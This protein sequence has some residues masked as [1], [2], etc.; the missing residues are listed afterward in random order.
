MNNIKKCLI[1]HPLS[2][3]TLLDIP[4]KTGVILSVFERIAEK[5]INIFYLMTSPSSR[6]KITITCL[7]PPYVKEEAREVFNEIV[8]GLE[9]GFTRSFEEVALVSFLGEG[10]STQKG[11][12]ADILN[13]FLQNRIKI[14][15]VST[16]IEQI[17][18]VI[19]GEMVENLKICLKEDFNINIE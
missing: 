4:D 14:L 10:L 11:I 6:G 2:L 1:K 5:D 17:N 15:G 3:F 7:V 8:D 18:F 12:V 13:V 19:P 16:G 9:W